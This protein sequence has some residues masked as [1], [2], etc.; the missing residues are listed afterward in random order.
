MF[1]YIKEYLR[2]NEV[3]YKEKLKLSRI[4]P[5]RI[6][7]EAR[8][9]V[10]PDNH[11]KFVELVRFL[12]DNGFKY[13]VFG[14]TSN[15]LFPD[16][17]YES[18]AVFTERLNRVMFK[19]NTIVAESGATL[20]RV[21]RCAAKQGICGCEELCGIPGTVG[22]SLIG[23]A[24]AFGRE[25]SDLFVSA[26]VYFL[27]DKKSV[28][29]SR[30]DIDFEYRNSNLKKQNCL[31][32]S[33]ELRGMRDSTQKIQA[34]MKKLSDQR[35]A[36]QPC[37]KPSLGSVFKK[38]CSGISAGALIDEC[39]LK[40]FSVGGAVISEKH[41]G[42]IINKGGSTASD[43]VAL[44]DFAETEVFRR[45]NVRLEKEIEVI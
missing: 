28:K 5:V 43:Y 21:C 14:K 44:A 26:N 4:S 7:G 39:G 37:D 12:G 15:V 41:A 25:I 35:L 27:E 20:P 18:I 6:G 29:L 40:G 42:F 1:E 34:R 33:L 17:E 36:H 9:A 30:C 11:N 13:K 23:N 22:A 2:I 16:G 45:F 38:T 31:V 3:E 10:Y 32:L 8:L 24:G 19:D